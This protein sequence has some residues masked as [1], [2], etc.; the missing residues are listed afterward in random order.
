MTNFLLQLLI[1]LLFGTI[2]RV[3]V[4]FV[5]FSV[6]PSQTRYGTVPVTKICNMNMHYLTALVKC[7]VCNNSF[8]LNIFRF[9]NTIVSFFSFINIR[10]RGR[11]PTP[12]TCKDRSP[13]CNYSPL[14][15]PHK[16]PT[17]HKVVERRFYSMFHPCLFLVDGNLFDSRQT[18]AELGELFPGRCQVKFPAKKLCKKKFPNS[19][20]EE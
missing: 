1:V 14:K 4:Q 19:K 9:W 16:S 2:N 17:L 10:V 12:N 8:V 18:F 11:E 3:P 7:A 5:K 15:A 20:Q 6:A 13:R